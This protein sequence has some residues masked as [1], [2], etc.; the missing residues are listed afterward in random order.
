MPAAYR[1]LT[2]FTTTRRAAS[3][4]SSRNGIARFEPI[5]KKNPIEIDP[6][7]AFRRGFPFGIRGLNPILPF[8]EGRSD[9]A[10]RVVYAECGAAP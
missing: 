7:R 6:A 5:Y 4:P 3:L 9:A 8:L 2:V 10:C 1:Y